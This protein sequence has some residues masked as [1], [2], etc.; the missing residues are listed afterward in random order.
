MVGES[1]L[2]LIVIL[3]QTQG[4]NTLILIKLWMRDGLKCSAFV[5][6][7][8]GVVNKGRH[9]H[10]QILCI[11]NKDLEKGQLIYKRSE[12]AKI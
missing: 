9:V 4:V 3:I 7:F 12:Q 1:T 11:T 2:I 5:L 8:I 10:I 6:T